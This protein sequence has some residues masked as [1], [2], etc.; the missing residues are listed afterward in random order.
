M[1]NQ[2]VG[3][4]QTDHITRVQ[5]VHELDTRP[6]IISIPATSKPGVIT[7]IFWQ[8]R[9][10]E[11][12]LILSMALYY[13]VGNPNINVADHSQVAQFWISFR[14]ISIRSIRSPCSLF[15]HF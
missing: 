11:A 2:N 7:S 15:L 6:S 5:D 8:H 14:N 13:L 12:G 3:V 9:L 10:A 1:S 4:S